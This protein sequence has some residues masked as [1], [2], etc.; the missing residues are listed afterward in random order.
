MKICVCVPVVETFLRIRR[1]CYAA[2]EKWES[3]DV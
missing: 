2:I 3:R 1:N